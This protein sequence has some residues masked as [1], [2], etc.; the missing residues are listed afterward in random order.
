MT[1]DSSYYGDYEGA[2]DSKKP[3]TWVIILIIV[4]VLLLC[5]CAVLVAGWFLGDPILEFLQDMGIDLG[6]M[7]YRIG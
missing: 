1:Q 2:S 7:L 6:L 4:A 3:K 5:C